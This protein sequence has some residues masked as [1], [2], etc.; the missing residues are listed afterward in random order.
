MDTMYTQCGILANDS[1]LILVTIARADAELKDRTWCRRASHPMGSDEASRTSVAQ[2]YDQQTD[3]N[4]SG[5][6]NPALCRHSSL[7]RSRLEAYVVCVWRDMGH[8]LVYP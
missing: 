5:C 3:A 8:T 6:V 2:G 7:A 1:A 4:R